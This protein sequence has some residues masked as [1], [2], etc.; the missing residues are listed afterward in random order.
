MGDA[1]AVSCSRITPWV[2]SIF[3]RIIPLPGEWGS[4][5]SRAPHFYLDLL[6]GRC[7][8]LSVFGFLACAQ[9]DRAEHR[10]QW[11]GTL[12]EPRWALSTG[13]A[14]SSTWLGPPSQASALL[15]LCPWSYTQ[16]SFCPWVPRRKHM[17]LEYQGMAVREGLCWLRDC[18]LSTSWGFPASAAESLFLGSHSSGNGIKHTSLHPSQTGYPGPDLLLFICALALEAITYSVIINFSRTCGIALCTVQIKAMLCAAQ[19]L[20]RRWKNTM[21]FSKYLD[22]SLSFEGAEL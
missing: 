7:Q 4:R 15:A 16:I 3:W 9:G 5:S 6:S 13:C 22:Y 14:V 18:P 8:S 21:A 12:A 19:T 10:W 17:G 2:L 11:G 1:V 20:S